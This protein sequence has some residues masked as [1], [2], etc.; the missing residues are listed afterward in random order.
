MKCKVHTHQA[1]RFLLFI[2]ERS[3]AYSKKVN[4]FK[5]QIDPGHE[6]SRRE[7]KIVLREIEG[8]LRLLDV[9]VQDRHSLGLLVTRGP[10]TP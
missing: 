10:E 7:G 8:L 3:S 4:T 5:Q 1:H 9:C 6:L 2:T